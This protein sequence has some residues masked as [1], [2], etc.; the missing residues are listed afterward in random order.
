MLG[1]RLVLAIGLAAALAAACA[2]H[3]L[4]GARDRALGFF[5]HVERGDPSW[6][7]IFAY[8][9][10]RFG[11]AVRGA[12]AFAGGAD[13]TRPEL[14]GVYE[15][16]FDPQAGGVEP[17]HRRAPGGGRPHDRPRP[18]L[19]PRRPAARL[20][21]AARARGG[22]RRVR[23]HARCRCGPVVARE[24]L[25]RAGDAGRSP[26]APGRCARSTG[27]GSRGGGR[28]LGVRPRAADRVART[29][30]LPGRRR[31]RAERMDRAISPASSAATAA[32]PAA[33][34]RSAPIRARRRSRCGCCSRRWSRR[35]RA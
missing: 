15:R 5:E 27:G 18:A 26:G 12:R 11:V 17:P 14:L 9:E 28:G 6:L 4:E 35:R 7:P 2:P 8:L 20:A 32:S 25:H 29:A 34:A 31:A 22:R 19:R 3:P 23:A 16:L 30:P 21:Q 1:S 13:V 24:R 10:R 33:R